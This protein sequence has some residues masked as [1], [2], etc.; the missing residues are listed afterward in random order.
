MEINP[1]NEYPEDARVDRET[2]QRF[3]DAWEMMMEHRAEVFARVHAGEGTPKEVSLN[4]K[5]KVNPIWLSKEAE[6]DG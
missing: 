1:F 3:S 2:W 5:Y 6:Q 4:L